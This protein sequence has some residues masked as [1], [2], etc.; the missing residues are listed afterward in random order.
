MNFKPLFWVTIFILFCG[1]TI[2]VPVF[3]LNQKE[4]EVYKDKYVNINAT[5]LEINSTF[6]TYSFDNHVYYLKREYCNESDVLCK[7]RIRIE[8]GEGEMTEIVYNKNE[9]DEVYLN[10]HPK[11]NQRKILVVFMYFGGITAFFGLGGSAISIT[12]LCLNFF[13]P[14]DAETS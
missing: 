8:K 5:L 1:I 12:F 11:Y 10:G 9:L 7:I 2:C 13:W 14:M 6:V 4:F 3:I